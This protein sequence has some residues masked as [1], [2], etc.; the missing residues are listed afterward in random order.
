MG[1]LGTDDIREQA[2]SDAEGY[3]A[4]GEAEAEAAA[5]NRRMSWV[6]RNRWPLM[7]GGPVVILGIAAYFVLTGGRTQTTEDSYVQIAKAPVAA[8]VSGRV[9]E[10]LVK[11]NQYVH[12]GDPLF[13]LDVRDLNAGV[14]QSTAQLYVTYGQVLA[15][16]ATYAEA[17]GRVA[18]AQT[19]VANAQ[20]KLAQA[21]QTVTFA[22]TE[23]TRTKALF[24]A[25][26]GSRDQADLAAH[27]LDTAKTE[28]SNAQ[29]AV[30]AA[31]S[32]VA[33][34]KSG[35][36]AALA[37]AG[38]VPGQAPEKHPLVVAA[39]ANLERAKLNQS[40]GVV[41]APVDGIV[42]R[43]DQLQPGAYIN[44]SQTAFWLLAGQPWVEA[45][46]KE[47]QLAKMKV[48]QPATIT[49]DAYDGGKLAGHVA[50]FSPGTGQAFSALP[51]QNATGNWVKVT[52]RLPVRIE[53]DHMPPEMAGRAGLSAKVTVD[54]TGPGKAEPAPAQRSA[55][56]KG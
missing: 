36:V 18:Q 49:V 50:S 47:D 25:G 38:N 14:D 46:F 43:V 19:I 8:S 20:A 34:A 16:K 9:V 44:A 42:T 56:P 45:N 10:V 40:Y 28:L 1:R 26:V 33:Q 23:A 3:S 30:T 31:Q 5:K 21:Q 41:T 11:E 53:F 27:N 6:S 7:I 37:N 39:Q 55:P 51:A 35:E 24:D 48:G 17:G 4:L 13:K 54:V 29:T 52:Q 2:L 15:L 12:K 32:Q 22:Q